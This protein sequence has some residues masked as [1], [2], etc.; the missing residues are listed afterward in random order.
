[1]LPVGL[2]RGGLSIVRLEYQV[3]IMLASTLPFTLRA[4]PVQEV[5]IQNQFL[6]AK[7]A[8]TGAEL[9]SLKDV[10]S[11]IEY[12]W[13]GDPDHWARQSPILFPIVG[14]LKDDEYIFDGNRYKLLQHGFAMNKAF[15]IVSQTEKGVTFSIQDDE[16]TL[17]IYP[18]RFELRITYELMDRVLKIGYMVINQDDK[19]MYFSIGGHPGFNC[20]LRP[21]EKRS[22]YQLVFDEKEDASIQLRA[23]RLRSG[24]SVTFLTSENAIPISENLFDRGALIFSN[25]KSKS[26]Q[27]KR[28]DDRVL[29]IHFEG[30]PNLGVWSSSATAPFICIEPWFGMTDPVYTNKKL[31]EKEGIIRLPRGKEFF[32]SYV[33]EL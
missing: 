23:G 30:F 8:C 3:F 4:Q 7:I 32:A 25:L 1:M 28:G 33:I 2:L 12:L 27:L 11:G 20:P 31:A 19:E 21:G 18:F 14:S 9:T 13:Q 6:S 15:R 17:H 26:V 22:D 16:K 29:T 5:M 24:G 10:Q